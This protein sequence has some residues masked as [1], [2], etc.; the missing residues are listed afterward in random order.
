[1]KGALIRRFTGLG[2]TAATT[3]STCSVV[4][5]RGAYRQSAPASA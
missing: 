3:A 1:M 5:I 2:A 4:L